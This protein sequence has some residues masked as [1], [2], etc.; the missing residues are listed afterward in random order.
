[1][2]THCSCFISYRSCFENSRCK[3]LHPTQ[4]LL[5]MHLSERLILH[6]QVRELNEMLDES[7]DEA[8]FLITNLAGPQPGILSIVNPY[9]DNYVPKSSQSVF[10]KQSNITRNY[11][12]SVN[13]FHWSSQRKCRSWWKKTRSQAKSILWF[14]Y[15][16]GKV[17]ASFMKS[18]CHTDSANPAWSLVKSICYTEELAPLA[19]QQAEVWSKKET[20]PTLNHNCFVVSNSGLVINLQW[21]FIGASPNGIIECDCCGKGILVYCISF[22]SILLSNTDQNLWCWILWLLCVHLS[23]RKRWILATYWTYLQRWWFL[24][25]MLGEG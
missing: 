6:L 23:N 8:S 24:E 12:K 7:I 1:M 11:W 22:I 19:K 13:L 4:S 5:I 14:E 10:P 21:S 20:I 9:S 16:A 3:D 15:R 2:H 18:V 25:N 17:T